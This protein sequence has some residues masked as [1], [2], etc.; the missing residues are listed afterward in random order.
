MNWK[1]TRL[2]VVGL[3]AFAIGLVCFLPARVAAGWVASSTPV[4]LGGVTGTLFEGQASYAS[5]PDGGVD[6][7]SWTLHP[8]SLLLGRASA[9]VSFNSDLDGFSADISRSLLSGNT[10]VSDASGNATLG[11]VAKLA[12]Y[13]FL[14]LSGSLQL[15]ISDIRFDDALAVS[16]LSGQVTIDQARWELINPPLALGRVQ[17]V[18][19]RTDAGLLRARVVDSSG[20]LAIK[21]DATLSQAQAYSLNAQLRSRAGADDRL[22]QLLTQ[23][24]RPDN[25]GWYRISERGRL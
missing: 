24:G 17:T 11:W 25:Q 6:N 1:T 10:H 18:L 23:I 12:G 21:G 9:H 22:K 15:D 4:Q 5:F 14:P 2:L 13:T 19:D 20:E 7:L 3:I 16:A 8:M